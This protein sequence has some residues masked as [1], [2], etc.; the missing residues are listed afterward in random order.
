M[1][2]SNPS[3]PQ[4]KLLLTSHAHGWA[5]QPLMGA[6]ETPAWTLGST[7]PDTSP[8]VE[9]KGKNRYTE[10]HGFPSYYEHVCYHIIY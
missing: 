1:N 8:V 10:Y 2:M 5:Q 7:Q 9:K 4:P 3:K 6:G